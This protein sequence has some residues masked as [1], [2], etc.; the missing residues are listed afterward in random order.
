MLPLIK[1]MRTECGIMPLISAATHKCRRFPGNSSF[2]P[3][4][5]FKTS[6]EQQGSE[7]THRASTRE[8]LT[9]MDEFSSGKSWLLET[10]Y[11]F[12][13]ICEGH[14]LQEEDDKFLDKEKYEALAAAD[15]DAAKDAIATAEEGSCIT[16]ER[17]IYNIKYVTFMIVNI[18][19]LDIEFRESANEQRRRMIEVI[20]G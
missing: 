20:S 9:Q 19:K 8:S 13:I 18:R 2:R 6:V 11:K 5:S 16:S 10:S 1:H 15:T 4:F 17:G 12:F 7:R 14:F 3:H